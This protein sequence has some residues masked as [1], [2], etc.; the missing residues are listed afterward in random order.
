MKRIG[1]EQA[2]QV[3]V[4]VLTNSAVFVLQF[5]QALRQ[6]V[7]RAVCCWHGLRFDARQFT[8]YFSINPKPKQADATTPE[9]LKDPF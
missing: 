9:L 4:Q 8:N 6:F 7:F 5:G 2:V 1:V 3:R